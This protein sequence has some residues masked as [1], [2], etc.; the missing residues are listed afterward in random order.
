MEKINF[1]LP[2]FQLLYFVA[3]FLVSL[4]QSGYN[5]FCDLNLYA[6]HFYH[7]IFR[8]QSTGR[9]PP[10]NLLVTIPI[11]GTMHKMHHY[12]YSHYSYCKQK[13]LQI[14]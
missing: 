12:Y 2:V 13:L 4:L 5:T 10:L 6:R 14:L 11:L 7:W 9:Y 8:K 1:L 3:H